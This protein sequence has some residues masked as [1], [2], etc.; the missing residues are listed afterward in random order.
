MLSNQCPVIPLTCEEG[1]IGCQSKGPKVHLVKGRWCESDGS[2]VNFI[3]Y[4]LHSRN[5]CMCTVR[6]M[7]GTV[8]CAQSYVAHDS[9]T[10]GGLVLAGP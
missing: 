2:F 5:I 10:P 4:V 9:V 1:T 6:N 3:H 7:T 8:F